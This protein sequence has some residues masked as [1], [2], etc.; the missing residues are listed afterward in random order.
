MHLQAN[1]GTYENRRL[2]FYQRHESENNQWQNSNNF[3]LTNSEYQ[4]PVGRRPNG[5][6]RDSKQLYC[7]HWRNVLAERNAELSHTTTIVCLF[8]N[9]CKKNKV[10]GHGSRRKPHNNP[11][12]MSLSLWLTQDG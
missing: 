7:P 3:Y 11:A 10:F 4:V 9:N 8:Y 12:P 2:V 6:I 1:S 5:G